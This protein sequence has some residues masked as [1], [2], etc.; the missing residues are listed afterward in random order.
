MFYV[1][2]SV[3][4]WVTNRKLAENMRVY[5]RGDILVGQFSDLSRRVRNGQCLEVDEKITTPSSL[6]YAMATRFDSP[7]H[8]THLPLKTI[9]LPSSIACYKNPM[10]RQKLNTNH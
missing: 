5:L 3:A 8:Y 6:Y 2:L 9:K 4:P 1:V 7:R 10:K